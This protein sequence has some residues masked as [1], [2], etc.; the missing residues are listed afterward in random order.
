MA[1][2]L[3]RATAT[4]DVETGKGYLKSVTVTPAAA[5]ATVDV[6]LASSAGA[7][8]LSLQ[9][10]ANGASVTW[11]SADSEAV[12]FAGALHAT[13]A[14]AGASASFEYELAS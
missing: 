1:T 13:L 2:K 7:I 9:A 12:Y 3:A 4:G 14:G 10:A 6:R 5:V 11:V 8:V